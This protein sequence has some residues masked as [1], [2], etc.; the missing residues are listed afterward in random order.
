[1]K[2]YWSIKKRLHRLL[3]P[4]YRLVRRR[5]VQL[6]LDSHNWI[7]TRLLIGQPYEDEQ[8][9]STITLIRERDIDAFIDVGANIGLYSVFVGL[10]TSVEI[11][12]FEPVSR[13]RHQL[14]G[15]LFVNELSERAQVYPFA[16]SDQPGKADIYIDPTSTG[17][18]RLAM[19]DGSRDPS[20]FTQREHISL[21]QLDDL[22]DWQG[23]RLFIKVDVEGHELPALRGMRGLLANNRVI[24]QV[25]AFAGDPAR[26][27]ATFMEEIGYQ[28]LDNP[29]GDY[30]F[31]NLP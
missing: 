8:I 3:H 10:A 2:I 11:H 21:A 12:A 4:R 22:L 14:C 1:M 6:L 9:A 28:P 15:N 18:S 25:E 5:G 31:S 7:D 16:L 20:V 27:L 24:L 23:R 17:V 19:D 30:R 29:G 13:N 26:A